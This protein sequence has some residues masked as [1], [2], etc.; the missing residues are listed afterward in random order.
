MPPLDLG[1]SKTLLLGLSLSY[2]V[3]LCLQLLELLPGDRIRSA[4]ALPFLASW[5]FTIF[6]LVYSWNSIGCRLW[7]G[8]CLSL[9]LNLNFISSQLIRITFSSHHP[10]IRRRFPFLHNSGGTDDTARSPLNTPLLV[11]QVIFSLSFLSRVLR[12]SFFPPPFVDD[13]PLKP[14]SIIVL[15]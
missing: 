9:F 11:T 13:S 12:M 15:P 5:A 8:W 6:Q 2:A 4:S 1:R 3:R 7:V 10:V 14:S